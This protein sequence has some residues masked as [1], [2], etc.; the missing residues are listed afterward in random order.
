MSNYSAI[1]V[2][3]TTNNKVHY[4]NFDI[5]VKIT[6]KDAPF[7]ADYTENLTCYIYAEDYYPMC[8]SKEYS[9][10][11]FKWPTWTA[12]ISTCHVWVPGNYTLFIRE[13]E[14]TLTRATLTIDKRLRV[15][16]SDIRDCELLGL[17]DILTSCLEE[18]TDSWGQMACKPGVAALRQE[19]LERT[20]MAVYNELRKSLRA[21]TLKVSSNLLIETVGQQDLDERT[22]SKFHILVAPGQLKMIDCST[23]YDIT[24]NNPYESLTEEIGVSSPAT[25]CLTNLS[26]LHATGGKVI[27]KRII[28]KLHRGNEGDIGIWMCGSRQEIDGVLEVFPSL[29]Q[30]FS[31]QRRLQLKAYSAFEMVQVFFDAVIDSGLRFS[32]EAMDVL[33]RAVIKGHESGKLAS[34]RIDDI[35][36]FVADDILPRYIKRT[37]ADFNYEKTA[38]L[39]PGDI[40]IE[41]LSG[42]CSAYEQSIRELNEMVGLDNIKRDITTMAN[43][44]KFYMER[45]RMGLPTSDKAVFHAIFTGNPGTGKTTVARMLGKI[46]HSLGLLSRGNVIAVDRTRIVG[47][48]IGETEENM[49]L[50]LEEARGN[51]LFIDEAYTLYDGGADRKDFGCRAIDCLLTVLSQPNPDMLIVFAGYEKEMDA[52]LSTNPGLFG[53]F[54]YKYRFSD[55]SADQ[56][57]QI[58]CHVLSQDEYVLTNEARKC[59]LTTIEQTLQQR[60]KNFGN[61]RWIEQYVRNGIIPALADR[62]SIIGSGKDTTLY[63]TVEAA[64]VMAAY[65]KFNPKTI[66][67]RPRRQ[68]GFSA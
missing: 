47:R 26:A 31:R 32:Y 18:R 53:R 22:L 30:F 55:Y 15:K 63:Q 13:K 4:S 50:L 62:V 7:G 52:M 27:V 68:I 24:C 42:G 57:M 3:L 19:A 54:P 29:K 36:R 43:R 28:D 60:T 56:L 64:D 65:E 67:L 38:L 35:R 33:S 40:D 1:K 10:L 58:G 51:V 45:R 8:N 37:I 25:L 17:E 20:Q 41:K 16:V 23:L 49:K 34:W 44:T 9:L 14:E 5:N 11:D 12:C 39:E 61:A 6:L 48:Y 66:E 21:A 59:L 46:Y 2:T